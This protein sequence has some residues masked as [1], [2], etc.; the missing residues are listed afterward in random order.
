MRD[1]YIEKGRTKKELR[2]V[3]THT[4]SEINSLLYSLDETLLL[5]V[6]ERA[7]RGRALAALPEDL[8]LILSTDRVAHDIHYFSPRRLVHLL[9]SAGTACMKL[10]HRYIL[11]V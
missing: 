11:H 1:L 8:V 6:V 5:G 9:A 10:V 4:K 2:S 7:Q 3:Y